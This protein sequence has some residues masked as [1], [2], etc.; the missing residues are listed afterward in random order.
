MAHSHINAAF[1][2]TLRGL[3]VLNLPYVRP[4]I[5]TTLHIYDISKVTTLVPPKKNHSHSSLKDIKDNKQ[6]VLELLERVGALVCKVLERYSQGG[7]S[8]EQQE[9]VEQFLK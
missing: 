6:D 1:L 8:A 9:D 2:T 3:G 4:L 7:S 5:D